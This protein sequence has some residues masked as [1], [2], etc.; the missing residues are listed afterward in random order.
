MRI[1]FLD[2]DGV[3]NSEDWYRRRPNIAQAEMLFGHEK[4]RQLSLR[5]LD[6]TAVARLNRIVSLTKA[7][8]VVS[9]SWRHDLSLP[10]LREYL[11]HHGFEFQLMG[12]TPDMTSYSLWVGP[13]RGCEIRAWLDMLAETP[14]YVILDDETIITLPSPKTSYSSLSMITVLAPESAIR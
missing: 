4:T 3:L 1:I 6:P 9:S 12:A 14:S 7:Q 11:H 2:I 10:R 13:D 8:V 5:N